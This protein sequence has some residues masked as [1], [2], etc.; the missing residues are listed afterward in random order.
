MLINIIS[1]FYIPLHNSLLRLSR[2]LGIE[3]KDSK[4]HVDK[5]LPSFKAKVLLF[6]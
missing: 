6:G 3:R 1:L 2:N 5:N 4:T